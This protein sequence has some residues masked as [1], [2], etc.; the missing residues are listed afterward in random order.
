MG[1]KPCGG[2][3]DVD[4]EGAPEGTTFCRRSSVMLSSSSESNSMLTS[5]PAPSSL[6]ANG[7]VFRWSRLPSTRLSRCS[8]AARL[9]SL[10]LS[11]SWLG[12]WRGMADDEEETD[13]EE[14][15]ETGSGSSEFFLTS[16]GGD[17]VRLPVAGIGGIGKGTPPLEEGTGGGGLGCHDDDEEDEEEEEEGS[18]GVGVGVG[19]G[20]GGGCKALLSSFLAISS[21]PSTRTEMERP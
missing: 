16:D 11:S 12:C 9:A 13:D 3:A 1:G 10:S 18:G 8:A 21:R 7:D 5:P 17:A 4:V 14:D 2:V 6:A 20:C 15:V 19:A